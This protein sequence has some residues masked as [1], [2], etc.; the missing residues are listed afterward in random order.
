M[1]PREQLARLAELYDQYQHSLKPLSVERAAAGSA[2]KE[3]LATLHATHAADLGF[4]TFRRSAIE[5]CR[6]YL[7]TNKPA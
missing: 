5:R 1:I 3:L 4:D 7:R 2:F 6:E